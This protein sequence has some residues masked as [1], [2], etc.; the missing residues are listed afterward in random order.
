MVEHFPLY[1]EWG[2]AWVKKGGGGVK[3]GSRGGRMGFTLVDL[4]R[5]ADAVASYIRGWSNAEVLRWMATWGVVLPA[6]H[7]MDDTLYIFRSAAGLVTGFRLPDEG[8]L[9]IVRDHT[10]YRAGGDTQVRQ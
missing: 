10:I 3:E 7:P 4:D 5:Q 1:S 2:Q 9:L 6:L 8:G